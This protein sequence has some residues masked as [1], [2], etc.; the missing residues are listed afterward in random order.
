M[1]SN[2]IGGGRIVAALTA[3]AALLG[4]SV[5]A[6]AGSFRVNP[7]RVELTPDRPAGELTL[8][9]VE[10]APVGVKVTALR[11][12][13]VNGLDVYEPT[14]DVIASP[15]IFTLAGGGTQLIRIG[16]RTRRAGAAYR[17]HV[18]EIPPRALTTAFAWL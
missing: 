6:I 2:I 14:T 1:I 5:P 3:A 11:W 12:T 7:V 16:L 8:S 15:P 9:N 13:Q 17:I 10:Q 18:E 4:V